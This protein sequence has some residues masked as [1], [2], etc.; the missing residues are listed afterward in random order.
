MATTPMKAIRAKCIDCCCGQTVEV[1]LCETTECACH[2]FRFGKR[3]ATVARKTAGNAKE[4]ELAATSDARAALDGS[5]DVPA[6]K[7][8]NGR[9]RKTS[10]L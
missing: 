5:S 9:A 7:G 8:S 3:P 2:P 4:R 10:L 6:K 1:R